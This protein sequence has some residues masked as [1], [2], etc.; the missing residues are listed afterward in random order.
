VL[1][2][3]VA[4]HLPRLRE[5]ITTRY[6]TQ[7]GRDVAASCVDALIALSDDRTTVARFLTL[8]ASAQNPLPAERFCEDG[9]ARLGAA[10]NEALLTEL[11]TAEEP[12]RIV[13]LARLLTRVSNV[14]SPQPLPT[15]VRADKAQRLEV[16]EQWRTRIAETGRLDPAP[17]AGPAHS[18][19]AT[20][21]PAPSSE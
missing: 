15:W 3:G 2:R 8:A 10:A 12:K 21:Q 20:T 4:G 11:T 1:T 5:L 13:K 18:A 6:R 17:L 14:R 19:P 16:V 7:T 9:L